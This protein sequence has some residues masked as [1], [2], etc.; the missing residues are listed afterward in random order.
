MRRMA[1]MNFVYFVTTALLLYVHQVNCILPP[2]LKI[3][4]SEA[5]FMVYVR[6]QRH[7]CGGV[8]LHERIVLTAN[9]CLAKNTMTVAAGRSVKYSNSNVQTVLVEKTLPHEEYSLDPNGI[10]AYNDVGLLLLATPLSF[11]KYVQP[12]ELTSEVNF[13]K[14]ATLYGWGSTDAFVNSPSFFLRAR[15][16]SLIDH[17]L[18]VELLNKAV[19]K[20]TKQEYEICGE[21]SACNGDSGSPIS[22]KVNNVTK[23]IGI[24]SWLAD[25][26]ISCDT[27]P[28]VFES[29]G[30]FSK[31]IKDGMRALLKGNSTENQDDN[32]NVVHVS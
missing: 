5:P 21:K 11:N 6:N 9:H 25:D 15:N 12:I 7:Y 4:A 30:H 31:W 16:I 20:C 10:Q 14:P 24:V 17:D 26:N 13:D 32:E 22:Q 1:A 3:D 2:S 29:I 28:A 8:I 27:S 18:C 23:L 19:T